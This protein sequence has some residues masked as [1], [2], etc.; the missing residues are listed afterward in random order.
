MAEE[1]AVAT[2]NMSFM[3]DKGL[4]EDNKDRQRSSEGTFLAQNKGGDQRLYWK[5]A[6]NLLDQFITEQKEKNIPC[7]I[8]LQEIN[9][10]EELKNKNKEEEIVGYKAINEMLKKHPGYLQV[11][12]EVPAWGGHVG[13]S[14]IYDTKHFGKVK[15]GKTVG[16]VTVG[17][18]KNESAAVA[19]NDHIETRTNKGSPNAGRPTLIVLTE[20]NYVFISAHGA[21]K[22]S[23]GK[24][25]DKFNEACIKLVKENVETIANEFLKEEDKDEIKGIFLMGDLNDR[26][27]AIKKF[28]ILDDRDLI[29]MG[30]APKSC[31]FNWDSSC[32]D[33]RYEKFDET[34][35][36]CKKDNITEKDENGKKN[37]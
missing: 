18:E 3:S 9:G 32:E 17:D 30:V 1:V 12:G 34:S 19:V 33:N 27:D 22:A 13:S 26:Y 8:G 16:E 37:Q 5:N 6:L 29:Y 10:H 20:K 25:K 23:E 15:D 11:C 2:Y 14:I 36:Y 31:C 28:T 24:N 21:Q 4:P 35:G 7:V